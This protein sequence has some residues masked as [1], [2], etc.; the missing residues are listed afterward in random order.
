MD[1]TSVCVRENKREQPRAG[2]PRSYLPAHADF[3]HSPL[4]IAFREVKGK[5][6]P[7]VGLKKTG[8][9]VRVNFG[10][11]PFIFD[12]DSVM[13]ACSFEFPNFRFLMSRFIHFTRT[14]SLFLACIFK[15]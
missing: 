13:K 12:I 10:Q 8:E 4:G 1:I 2:P 3:V 15:T 7:S 14:L 11:T 5:L 9:H 6:Y